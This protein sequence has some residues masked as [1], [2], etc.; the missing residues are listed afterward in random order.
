VSKS[1]TATA[2]ASREKPG[3]AP[4]SIEPVLGRPTPKKPKKPKH[5]T[6]RLEIGELKISITQRRG[7]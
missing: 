1:V 5:Q 3:S 2:S 6:V 4:T 7:A